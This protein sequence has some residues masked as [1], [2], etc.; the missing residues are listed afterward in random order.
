MSMKDQIEKAI[1]AHEAWKQRL[2]AAIDSG[3]STFDAATVATDNACDFGKWLYSLGD[4][5]KGAN[6]ESVR[7]LH[8][9]FHALAGR[10]L[11]LATGGKKDE[12]ASLMNGEFSA[13]SGKLV[14]T[15][16]AWA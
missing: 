14:S 11:G 8:A 2:T 1:A 4:G 13:L 15:L 10:I 9:D 12:A 16:N 6:F 7:S 5:D 3:S